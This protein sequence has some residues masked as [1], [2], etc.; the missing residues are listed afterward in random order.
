MMGAEVIM[1]TEVL[2]CTD[3]SAPAGNYDVPAGYKKVKGFG[4]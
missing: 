2:E 4:K 3:K 1:T